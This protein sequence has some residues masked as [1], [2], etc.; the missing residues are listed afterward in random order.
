MGGQHLGWLARGR[1][2]A[3]GRSHSVAPVYV[4]PHSAIASRVPRRSQSGTLRVPRLGMAA[5][6]DDLTPAAAPAARVL[7]RGA[8]LGG[9]LAPRR[10]IW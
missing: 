10:Q 1:N 2:H 9:P 3:P 6:R 4:N 5:A 8:A 7:L